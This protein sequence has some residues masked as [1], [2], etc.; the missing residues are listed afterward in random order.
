MSDPGIHAI[1]RPA[2]VI[3]HS[4]RKVV[5]GADTLCQQFG[6]VVHATISLLDVPTTFRI[7]VAKGHARPIARYGYITSTGFSDSIYLPFA[8]GV[9][10]AGCQLA[11]IEK[12]NEQAFSTRSPLDLMFKYIATMTCDG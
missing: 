7:T 1:E 6:L 2:F 11:R 3:S 4:A 12:Y 5:G 9:L 10:Q 8:N